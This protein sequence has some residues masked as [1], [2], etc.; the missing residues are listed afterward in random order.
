MAL[1]TQRALG[2][3]L[4]RLLQQRPLSQITVNDI[5]EECGVARQTF[6][7]HFQDI[8]DLLQWIF[9][10]AATE[11]SVQMAEAKTWRAKLLLLFH[12]ILDNKTLV[13][14]VYNSIDDAYIYRFIHTIP[15]DALL[16]S[17]GV[18]PPHEQS[19]E[20]EAAIAS[21]YLRLLFAILADWICT[22]MRR[23]PEEILDEIELALSINIFDHIK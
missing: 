13:N 8:Y 22:G 19:A 2:N 20:E 6:Y 14:N 18:D 11:M 17:F 3:A 4:V 12:S 5:V 7:Y 16:E 10:Q 1:M 21:F 15:Y 9:L 23:P